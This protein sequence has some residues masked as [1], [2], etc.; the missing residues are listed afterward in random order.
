M[1]LRV[2]GLDCCVAVA[3][4]LVSFVVCWDSLLWGLL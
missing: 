2:S 4:M 1:M 3:S